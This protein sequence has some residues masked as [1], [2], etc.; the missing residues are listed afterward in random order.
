MGT[1]YALFTSAKLGREYPGEYNFINKGISGNRVTD[2]YARIKLDIINLK[3]DYMSI[4]IGVNDV[5]HEIAREDG[6]D[7]DKF[8][9]IYSD[10]IEEVK[11]ALPN[12]KIMI[13][14][15]FCLEAS[16]TENTEECPNKWQIFK[17]EVEKRAERAKKV[18]EKY[19]LP[20]ITLQDKFDEAAKN[21]N[22]ENSYWLY[23]GVHPTAMGHEIIKNEWIKA[24]EQIR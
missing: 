10:L 19:G 18:A 3:P 16:A 21:V 23:D 6:V 8:E 22:T 9:R 24:F 15:P 11:A 13:F 2:L 14:A 12:I 4:L 20:F 5:W 17:S 1:G 7:A